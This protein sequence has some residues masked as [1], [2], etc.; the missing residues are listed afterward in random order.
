MRPIKLILEG[1]TSFRTRQEIDFDAL[2]NLFVI[3]GPTGAGKTSLLD[4]ITFALYGKVARKLNPADLVTQG[5]KQLKVELHFTSR[6]ETYRAVRTYDFSRKTATNAIVLD[7]FDGAKW[8]RE[9]EQQ[10][11]VD[12]AIASILGIDYDTFTRVILLPQGEFDRFLKG[13]PRHRREILRQLIPELQVFELMRQKAVEREKLAAGELNAIA[14]QLAERSLPTTEEIAAAE[15]QKREVCSRIATTTGHIE[16]LQQ[17]LNDTERLLE[18]QQ[19]L[20]RARAEL[21]DLLARENVIQDITAKLAQAQI[22]AQLE[23]DWRLV[24]DARSRLQAATERSESEDAAFVAARAIA[25]RSE[26]AFTAA[27][28]RERELQGREA[29]LQAAASFE[30]T[31]ARCAEEVERARNLQRQRQDAYERAASELAVAHTGLQQAETEESQAKAVV[32]NSA[33]TGDRLQVLRQVLPLLEPWERAHARRHQAAMNLETATSATSATA[34][35]ERQ[36]SAALAEAETVL[37]AVTNRLQQARDDN[38]IAMLRERLHDG[39]TCPVCNSPYPGTTAVPDLPDSKVELWEA[40]HAEACGESERARQDFNDARLEGARQQ[41]QADNARQ[42]L[43]DREGDLSERSRQL[44]DLLGHCEWD[45]AAL[46]TELQTLED[47]D[48]RYQEARAQLD[49]IRDRC[50]RTRSQL[51]AAEQACAAANR[52]RDRAVD[53]SDRRQT[54]LQNAETDLTE[55]LK[56][57]YTELGKQPYADLARILKQQRDDCDR[58]VQT[59]TSARDTGAAELIRAETAAESAARELTTAHTLQQ[60]RDRSWTV[61]CQDLGCTEAEFLTARATPQQQQAWH[62]QK[63]TYEKQHLELTVRVAN[64]QTEIGGRAADAEAIV[65]L[66]Q[67]LDN[68]RDRGDELQSERERITVWLSEQQR[69]A[70]DVAKLQAKHDELQKQV[71]AL[72]AIA[73][74]L[75]SN[76][77]QGYILEAFEQ[78]LALQGSRYLQDLTRRYTLALDGDKYVVEDGWNGGET[79]PVQTLSG[80]ETFVASLSVGLALSELLAGSA[81]VGSLFLDEGFGTLDPETLESAIQALETLRRSHRIV[82]LITHVRELADRLPAQIEV[83][84]SPDGSRVRVL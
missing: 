10:R 73:Q 60:E 15:L 51:Q 40:Q 24:E 27:I 23:G 63:Q 36:A 7:R 77:F 19:Q 21:T 11:D 59:A 80:G 37:Q 47:R 25:E 26:V 12:G 65:A 54:Q 31:R 75:Q 8:E 13:T 33:P 39:E 69:L 6:G 66:E 49:A 46:Q 42:L 35:A 68:A 58:A 32:E 52:E 53:D 30:T 82:G 22:A 61:A 64:L 83:T 43:A 4:A 16:Q 79:R 72:H 38:A 81:E 70:R 1:F 57:L 56:R 45:S 34:A 74:Q 67:A 20:T 3:T 44:R 50:I 28:D 2:D 41:Q 14:T 18:R 84:K 71:D 62:E 5:A 48:R 76:Q 29:V 78:D 9:K 17:E 55:A